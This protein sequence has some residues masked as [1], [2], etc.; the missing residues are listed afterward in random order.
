MVHHRQQR[1][2]ANISTPRSAIATKRR[3]R[4]TR[5]RGHRAK[6]PRP[7][8]QR[9]ARVARAASSGGAGGRH[10][11]PRAR[12]ACRLRLARRL[13]RL[14]RHITT[15]RHFRAIWQRARRDSTIITL[16]KATR[17]PPPRGSCS[18]ATMLSLMK[19]LVSHR[20][21]RYMFSDLK[22]SSGLAQVRYATA[23]FP[24]AG[25]QR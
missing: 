2:S 11:A 16:I 24:Q 17:S 8:W 9:V 7:P 3:R 13:H 14:A 22:P 20:G 4:S 23:T 10:V 15:W 5:A 21:E 18:P 1:A 12:D 6:R 25:V 19:V